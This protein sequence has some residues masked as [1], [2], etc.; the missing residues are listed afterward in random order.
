MSL[1]IA[2]SPCPNDTFLFHAWVKGLVGQSVP[3][4]PLLADI[5]HLNDWVMQAKHPISKVSIHCLGRI[6]EQYVLLPSGC[7]LGYDCGPKIISRRPLNLQELREK[8]VAIPGQGTTAHLL[9]QLLCDHPTANSFCRYDQII[10]LLQ[11]D[12]ADA[13]LIIHETRFNFEKLGFVEVADLGKLWYE[14]FGLPVPLGG[15]VAKRELGQERLE[16]I[17]NNIVR[18]L[19]YA[20]KHPEASASYILEHSQEKDPS[21][22]QRHIDLYVTQ[23]TVSLSEL[24]RQ[25]I[26]KLLSL[27]RERNL[28]PPSSKEWLFETCISADV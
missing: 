27:A 20:R 12:E 3:V 1:G 4:T 17:T 8:R 13:G 5:Q 16:A 14:R 6:L 23:E 21:I 28:L 22:I 26:D 7:A 19:A 11:K 18:S 24:G 10:P 15:V 9:F 25:A 2:F